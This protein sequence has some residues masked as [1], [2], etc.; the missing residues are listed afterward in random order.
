MRLRCLTLLAL[1]P[2]TALGDVVAIPAATREGLIGTWEAIVQDDSAAIGVYQMVI[3]KEG[4]AHLIQLYAARAG[5]PLSNFFGSASSISLDRGNLTIR[6]VMAPQHRHKD[7]WI[8][9]RAYAA[10]LEPD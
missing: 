6:F 4:D 8:E 2:L 9:I 5:R 10:V 1:L 3:P 7:D